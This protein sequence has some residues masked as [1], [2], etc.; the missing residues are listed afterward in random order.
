M[1]NIKLSSKF[2]IILIGTGLLIGCGSSG[3]TSSNDRESADTKLDRQNIDKLGVNVAEIIPGCVY[4]GETLSTTLDVQTLIAYKA[5]YSSITNDGKVIEK[6]GQEKSVDKLFQGSCG[7]TMKSV[8]TDDNGDIN[9]VYTFNNYCTGDT[10]ESTTLNGTANVYQDGEPSDSGSVLKSLAISTGSEG[11]TTT[12]VV[13]GESITQKLYLKD[14][15]YTVGTPKST[16]TIKELKLDSSADGTYRVTDVNIE[17]GGDL[18]AGTVQIKNATYYDPEI[19]AV[20]VSTSLIPLGGTSTATVSI[21]I[22]GNSGNPVTFTS[23]DE[24]KGLF[25]VSQ[26]GKS[27]GKLDCSILDDADA[28]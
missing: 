10:S 26:D 21:T 27:V 11:I 1:K 15:K 8:G 16:L 2:A 3:G 4:T 13:A 9:A 25:S 17:Q 18:G 20:S 19:G 22:K 23:T 28:L 12:V 14:F 5:L 6:A 24:N 7:G